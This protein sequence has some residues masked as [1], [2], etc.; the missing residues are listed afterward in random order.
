MGAELPARA[1]APPGPADRLG[2]RLARGCACARVLLPVPRTRDRAVERGPSLHV[3]VQARARARADERPG[4]GVGVRATL[5]PALPG[6][7][8][9][10]RGHRALPVR[11]LPTA[12]ARGRRH[13][14]V[15]RRV[16][17]RG[18]ASTRAALPR[19]AGPGARH[20]ALPRRGRGAAR[21]R[22]PVTCLRHALRAGR[23]RGP[24][25]RAPES[26]ATPRCRARRRGRWPARRVL[27]DP[28][29]V[30]LRVRA[31]RP[32]RPCPAVPPEPV[33]VRQPLRDPGSVPA[34]PVPAHRDVAPRRGDA[35]GRRR[36][37]HQRAPA[38]A[39]GAGDRRARVADG[40]RLRR[41][42][43]RAAAERPPPPLLVPGSL[44]AG[45]PRDRGREPRDPGV[46][47]A[48][49][50]TGAVRVARRRAAPR[51]PRSRR[52]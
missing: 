20:P 16:R 3:H 25:S 31:S 11:P 52:S 19:S 49:P 38:G 43:R 28:A 18:R 12:D 32:A 51:C 44:P 40:D 42:T 10:G 47:R 7:C 36:R 39:D 27:A 45:C 13:L 21:A 2:S 29:A 1:P 50:Q 41:P 35:P 23:G 48:T 8:A 15:A 37:R 34:R 30:A 4:R 17:L 6:P 24:S 9:H 33:P 5:G 46:A 14:D 26:P 22:R